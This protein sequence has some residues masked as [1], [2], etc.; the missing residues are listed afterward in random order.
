MSVGIAAF[1]LFDSRL[2][3]HEDVCQGRT[4]AGEPMSLFPIRD[5]WNTFVRLMR[6]LF[7]FCDLAYEDVAIVFTVLCRFELV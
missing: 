5:S 6:P 1:K 2:F 3:N 4:A 7:S